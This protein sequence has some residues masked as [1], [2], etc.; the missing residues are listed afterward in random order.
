MGVVGKFWDFSG[1]EW[2]RMVKRMVG[3][4]RQS[5]VKFDVSKPF[6]SD[7]ERKWKVR[8]RYTDATAI[9]M[10]RYAMQRPC[11]SIV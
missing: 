4:K 9:L 2:G 5:L 7:F 10:L 11:V 8:N 3:H 1:V 6:V